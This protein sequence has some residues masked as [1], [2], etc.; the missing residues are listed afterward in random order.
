MDLDQANPQHLRRTIATLRSG[1]LRATR[2]FDAF[3]AADAAHVARIAEMLGAPSAPLHAD[4]ARIGEH[5]RG[6]LQRA[7]EG[8]V[9]A[10]AGTIKELGEHADNSV[11]LVADLVPRHA[12]QPEPAD[13]P[14]VRLRRIDSHRLPTSWSRR[15]AACSSAPLTSLIRTTIGPSS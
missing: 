2:Q 3:A 9:D 5:R 6:A 12:A 1:L 4:I 11:P 13:P 10:I 8:I 15:P 7:C 14:T